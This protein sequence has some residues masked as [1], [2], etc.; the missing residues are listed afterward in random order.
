MKSGTLKGLREGTNEEM[1]LR[2]GESSA[3]GFEQSPGNPSEN[4]SLNQ[5]NCRV[6]ARFNQR[7]LGRN[8]PHGQG[9]GEQQSYK[10]ASPIGGTEPTRLPH[11]E[12]GVQ[13]QKVKGRSACPA[14]KPE[15]VQLV[16]GRAK[17]PALQNCEQD[18]QRKQCKK[19]HDSTNNLD[20]YKRA[21]IS[22]NQ[23]QR[24]HPSAADS[25]RD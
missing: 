7:T 1:H 20:A 19:P 6:R 22:Q 10:R 13:R 12:A 23:W 17:E 16:C 21:A 3:F 11:E 24:Q 5:S 2:S 4:Q 8:Y 18:V 15:R 14:A 25:R 9:K